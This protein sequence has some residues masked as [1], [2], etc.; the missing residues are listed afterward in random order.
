MTYLNDVNRGY[1]FRM[2]ERPVPKDESIRH[3]YVSAKEYLRRQTCESLLKASLNEVVVTHVLCTAPLH[4]R[5]RAMQ[6][7]LA[8]WLSGKQHARKWPMKQRQEMACISC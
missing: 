7:M 6:G 4:F 5:S 8:G 3:G 1:G 2:L